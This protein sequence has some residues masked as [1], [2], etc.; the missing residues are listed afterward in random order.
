MAEKKTPGRFTLQFNMR[1]PQQRSAADIINNQGRAKAQFITSAVLHYIHCPETPD[2]MAVP[3]Q[4]SDSELEQRL[5]VLLKRHFP[6]IGQGSGTAFGGGS[7]DCRT[8]QTLIECAPDNW[9]SPTYVCTAA[10]WIRCRDIA[11]RFCCSKY[12]CPS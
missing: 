9:W 1:D 10:P 3:V 8:A 12:L 6:A 4:I 5:L 11:S 2:L 7:C